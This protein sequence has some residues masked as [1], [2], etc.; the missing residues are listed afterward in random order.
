MVVLPIVRALLKS[1]W[2]AAT[3]I[4]TI[5]L[6]IALG[7]TVFAVVDGVLFKPLPYP[8]ADRL[9]FL[10]GRGGPGEGT[11]SLAPRDVEYLNDADPRISVT[12]Y[13]GGR[14]MTPIDR[15][16][17]TIGSASIDRRFLEVL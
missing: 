8:S 1:P 15:P 6:T 10:D 17:V 3:S 12:G 7:S 14:S 11:A 4:G 2:H 16:D 9:F 5:A 13:G